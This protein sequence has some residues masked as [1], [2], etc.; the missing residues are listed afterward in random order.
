MKLNISL[1][2]EVKERSVGR[3]S[4]GAYGKTANKAVQGDMGWA[5]SEVREAQSKISFE[6]RL[7]NMHGT[8]W[9]DRVHK[10]LYLKAW[11]RMEEEVKRMAPKYR[12]IESANRQPESE[13]IWDSE[14]HAKNWTKKENGI[15]WEWQES[16]YIEM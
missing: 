1:G 12:A 15:L 11:Q 2:L 16:N 3:L 6:E 4:L 10:Y 13:K 5:S 7:R 8:E 9:E 14:F